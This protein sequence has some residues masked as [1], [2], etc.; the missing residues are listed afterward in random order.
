MMYYNKYHK[1]KKKYLNLLHGNGENKEYYYHGS[2]TKIEDYLEPM[3]GKTAVIGGKS[4][5]FATNKYWFALSFIPKWS[6]GDISNGY[7]GDIPY[8]GELTP[9]AFDVFKGASG[10]MYYVDPSQFKKDKRLMHIE[11]VSNDKVKILKTDYIED[12]YKALLKTEVN[13]VT[14]DMKNEA[15]EKYIPVDTRMD[16]IGEYLGERV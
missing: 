15:Y 1:Y 2:S 12:V 9:N 10:Y 3:A 5:V 8:L 14:Y 4:A 11:F 7:F 6:D 13:M 16:A